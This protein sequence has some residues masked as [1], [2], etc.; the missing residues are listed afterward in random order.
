MKVD[1]GAALE[2]DGIRGG[3][4]VGEDVKMVEE[5]QG[6]NGAGGV[7]EAEGLWEFPVLEAHV[8]IATE[9]AAERSTEGCSRN[10]LREWRGGRKAGVCVMNLEMEGKRRPT[11]STP[12]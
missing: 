10:N 5:E 2:A 4:E 1:L 8:E 7:V 3:A 11:A 6:E 9:K 12:L